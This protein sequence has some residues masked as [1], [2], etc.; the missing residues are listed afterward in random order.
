MENIRVVVMMGGP[1][2]EHDV[3]LASGSE[4]Y[5]A[6]KSQPAFDVKAL[7]ISRDGHWT[8]DSAPPEALVPSGGSPTGTVSRQGAIRGVSLLAQ[9]DVVFLAFHGTFGEDGTLQG[10]LET[11]GIP[12]TGSGPL[13]SALAMNKAKAK[14]LF[15]YHG[16]ATPPGVVLS[17]RE[18]QASLSSCAA[19]VKSRLTYPLVVK[20]N[21]GGSS[22]GA[23][24]VDDAV[25]L[26]KALA[27]ASRYDLDVLVEERISG[28]EFTCAVLE[29]M[30][31]QLRALPVIEIIPKSGRFFDFTAKYQTG[32]A[33]EICPAPIP[34]AMRDTIQHMAIKAHDVLGCEGLS[35]ADMIW[36]DQGPVLLEVNTIPGMTR[37]SLVPKAAR[38]AGIAFEGLVGHLVR[39]ALQRQQLRR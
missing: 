3:S 20:P 23:A 28:R 15:Q 5:H 36:T 33:D 30:D 6:L 10:L 21:V 39:L 19:Y 29:E 9:A 24:M 12:Y 38:A 37:N 17:R 8:L 7:T 1:S 35:R 13:A 11:L 25:D 34:D 14:E 18:I 2:S 16:L 4:V 26:E 27:D 31:G 22:L 32:A